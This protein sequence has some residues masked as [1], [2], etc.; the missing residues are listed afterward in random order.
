MAVYVDHMR[1]YA[2]V[3]APNGR[4]YKGYWTHLIAD[5]ET[6]LHE[7]AKRLGLPRAYCHYRRRGDNNKVMN[8]HYDLLQNRKTDK[9]KEAL[10]LGATRVD[11]ETALRIIKNMK[12]E[13][14][15]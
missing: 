7:F 6:E 2:E 13:S 12:L 10:A 14:E 9:V 15:E 3:Q 8:C 11:R 1:H 4:I 5:D